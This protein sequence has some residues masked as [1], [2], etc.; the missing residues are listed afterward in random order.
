M[1][2]DLA[3]ALRRVSGEIAIKPGREFIDPNLRTFN[4][5]FLRGLISFYPLFFFL[6]HIRAL[7]GTLLC[8]AA[9]QS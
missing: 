7:Q 9:L 5:F 8:K 4:L 6:V 3:A 2:L 1:Q